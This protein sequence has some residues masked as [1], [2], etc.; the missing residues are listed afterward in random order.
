[1]LDGMG[2]QVVVVDQDPDAF[3][4]LR[5]SFAGEKIVGQA[6]ER[7]TFQQA[8]AEQAD[9]FVAATREDNRNIVAALAA[10]HHFKV[11]KVVARIY[12][13]DR[14]KIY[15]DQGLLTLSPVDWAA[16]R[17]R[18]MLVHAAVE[19]EREFETGEVALI[20]MEVPARLRGKLV[21]DVSVA[22]DIS[23]VVISRRGRSLLPTMGTRFEQG[24]IVRFVVAREAYARFESLV[25]LK[26]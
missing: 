12:D 9:A 18:D 23:V 19:T 22:G 10:K 7:H 2:H 14:A 17:I 5:R 26:E 8:G 16:N 24:D 20:R 21:A 15:R 25:G 1:M 13:P 11:P 4:Q 6:H 3:A